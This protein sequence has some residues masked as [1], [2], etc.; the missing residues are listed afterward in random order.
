MKR[1]LKRVIV[2]LLVTA[3]LLGITTTAY[4][5]ENY[6]APTDTVRVG[7]YY[8]DGVTTSRT[9]ASANLQNVDGY[10]YGYEMG[11]YDS[12]RN[13]ISL[14]VTVTDTNAITMVV[15]RNLYYN[16]GSRSYM[17]G[18]SGSVVVG[19]FHYQINESFSD[20]Q[21]AASCLASLGTLSSESFIKYENGKYYV[22]V[23]NY[24]S[25]SAAAA[26]APNV[27]YSGSVNSGT[28]YT[29]T[30][31]ETG[32]NRILFEFDGG[33]KSFLA[34]R[35]ISTQGTKTLTYYKN[36]RYY[37][38][39]SY[40]RKGTDTFYVVNYVNIED[41]VKGV[42]PY[43]MLASWPIEALKA[44]AVC[45]RT[46]AMFYLNK[47][48]SMGFDICN[49]TD[50]QVYGGTNS[51]NDVTDRAVNET[52]GMYLTYDGKLCETFYYSSNGGASESSENVW[53]EALPY[54]RG[55]IDPYEEAVIDK[56]SNYNWSVTYTG[57]ELASKLQSKGY[58]CGTI[59][60][61][62]ILEFTP[63]G[64][65][66]RIRFTDS[67]GKTFTFSK[68]NCRLILG[69]RSQRYTIN[70]YEGSANGIYVNDS[71]NFLSSL[72]ENLFAVGSGGTS[73][74]SGGDTYAITSTGDVE[75]IETSGTASSTGES[76]VINGS[77]WGH[78]VGMSQWGAYSMAKIYGKTYLDILTFYYTDAVVAFS[79]QL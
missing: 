64:N 22:C 3:S 67:N 17:E 41:Y 72:F 6:T 43:E 12:N 14:G 68:E 54:L 15:D 37:G 28:S 4:A 36:V 34:V 66:K 60:K 30:V 32:T 21:S 33:G 74:L 2:Y 18:T 7:L 44:L 19:C 76:F 53:N 8:N 23:G 70:G 59:T 25:S 50:C 55:V 49:T 45:A 65:V 10:G 77:G 63:T 24:T 20:Y 47:H 62:E 40:V 75:K 16:S 56:I 31:V 5:D 42:L 71:D 61:F 9:F 79:Q 51:A 13:F 69:L 38:N 39:F 1:T 73:S 26:V 52:S 11:Y 27:P 58:S 57:S 46:Y 35:P 29:M 78:N 48:S